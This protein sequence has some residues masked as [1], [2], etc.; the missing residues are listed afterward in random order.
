MS[1]SNFQLTQRVRRIFNAAQIVAEENN[2]N[3]IHPVHLLI[4]LLVEI[5]PKLK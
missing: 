4:G 5:I 1:N 3:I 2:N